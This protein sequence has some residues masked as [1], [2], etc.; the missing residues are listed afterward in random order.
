MKLAP[1]PYLRAVSLKPD[2]ERNAREYPFHIPAVRK[3]DT[4]N[5]HRD[6]TF[7]VGENGTGKSTLLEAIAIAW[8]FNAEGGSRNFHFSTRASHSDLYRHLRLVRSHKRPRDGYFLRAESFFNVA[9]QIEELDREGGGPK[10]I[11][12]YGGRSLHEQSHGESFFALMHGRFRGNGLYV[13]DEPEA[14]LSPMRQLQLLRRMDEL[15]KLESQ[16]LIATHSPMLLAY[17]SAR[18]LLLDDA[19]FREVAY[20]DTEHYKTTRRF[21]DAPEQ[22]LR[23][24]LDEEPG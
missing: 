20:R 6:V 18:I 16:F 3:L 11:D 7:L 9:T 21:F 5:L 14:A 22:T 15:V 19:G 13:L 4:L 12:S 10:I 8:G 17:P 2:P 1:R 24:Y 23:R